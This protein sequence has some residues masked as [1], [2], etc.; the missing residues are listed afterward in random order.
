MFTSSAPF[1]S[2]KVISSAVLCSVPDDSIIQ[3]SVDSSGNNWVCTSGQSGF[4]CSVDDS[5]HEVLCVDKEHCPYAEESQQIHITVYVSTESFLV[6]NYS[7]RFFLS[8]IG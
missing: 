7:T 4:F 3:C 1:D 6:E 5:G 8:E 2:E